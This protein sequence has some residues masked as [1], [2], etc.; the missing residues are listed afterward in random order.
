MPNFREE[1]D[2]SGSAR[3]KAKRARDRPYE[4]TGTK[5]AF[6]GE[7]V[8]SAEPHGHKHLLD[9]LVKHEPHL[10]VDAPASPSFKPVSALK[11]LR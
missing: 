2:M 1:F 10:E 3:M 6:S 4:G 8:G 7:V 5:W 9:F 11:T